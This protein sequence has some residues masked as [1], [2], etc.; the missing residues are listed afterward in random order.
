MEKKQNWLEGN[1][2]APND[3]QFIW[4]PTSKNVKF[5][6]LAPYLSPQIANHFEFHQEITNKVNLLQNLTAFCEK[7][8]LSINDIMPITFAIDLKSKRLNSQL[9]LFVSYFKSLK[10]EKSPR[11]KINEGPGIVPAVPSTH[12]AG[13]N[14]WLI[15]PSGNN[16]GRGIH[17]FNDSD[18]FKALIAESIE[19]CIEGKKKNS[20][21]L[22]NYVIQKYIESP[23][24]I[25]GRKFD[26]RVWVLI[27][28]KMKGF[29]YKQGYARTS[30]E[31]F[32][33]EESSLA[34]TFVHLTNNAVQ[35]EGNSYGKFEKGNQLSFKD[36]QYYFDSVC[37]GKVNFSFIVN[38]MKELIT[39]TL[40]S[41]KKKLNPNCREFCFEVFGYDFIIDSECQAW[42]IECNTNPCIELSSPLLESLI[43][44]MLM[45]AISLTVD[46][47]FPVVGAEKQENSNWEFLI[48]L[49]K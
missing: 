24:L 10:G 36:I 39:L 35:K 31:P 12:F 38:R 22:S 27:T 30:S 44:N 45:E 48:N 14:I 49:K 16:R 20:K 28:Y 6:R 17:I 2:S 18:S 34:D 25:H 46:A 29:F 4:H 40:M 7:N 26:I 3:A 23:L 33:T 13:K 1:Y 19:K 9:L 47:V 21:E 5:R 42:L 43:P 15:K 32:S 11:M 8:K 41:V 37:P